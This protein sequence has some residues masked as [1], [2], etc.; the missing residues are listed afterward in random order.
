MMRTFKWFEFPDEN[1]G[2]ALQE[3]QHSFFGTSLQ[4]NQVGVQ[5]IEPLPVFDLAKC[6]NDLSG[7]W[8]GNHPLR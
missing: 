1:Q 8:R 7:G 4:T 3:Q 5:N 6:A 2:P